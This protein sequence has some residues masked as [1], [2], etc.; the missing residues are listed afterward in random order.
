MIDGATNS[1]QAA[2]RLQAQHR[3]SRGAAERRA[4]EEVRTPADAVELSEAA[5]KELERFDSVPI[6][7]ELVERVRG[8]IAAGEYTIDDKLDAVVERLHEVLY[9]GR[10]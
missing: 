4:P 8:A 6:R 3:T 2:G 10:N 1:V 5:R 9:D 7:T